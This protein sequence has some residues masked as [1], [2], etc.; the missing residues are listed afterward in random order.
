MGRTRGNTI[1]NVEGSEELV[2]RTIQ[3]RVT[4]ATAHALVGEWEPRRTSAREAFQGGY[5]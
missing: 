4:A 1:V 2:G 5:A 3:V